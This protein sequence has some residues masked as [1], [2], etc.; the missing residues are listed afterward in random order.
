MADMIK[1]PYTELFSRATTIRQQADSVRS[2]I[3]TLSETIGSIQWMGNR[4]D[5][6]FRM[7]DDSKPKMEEW[8]STLENFAA[9]LEEQARRMQDADNR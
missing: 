6:F 9:D 3:R 4:A 8:A 5:K 2:E 7:W 1:V